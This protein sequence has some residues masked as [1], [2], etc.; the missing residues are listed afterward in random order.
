MTAF[1]LNLTPG[2]LA[3]NH[4]AKPYL[5]SP[6]ELSAL[7][8]R[9]AANADALIA[10]R[11]KPNKKPKARKGVAKDSR[12]GRPKKS[13]LNPFY[14]HIGATTDWGRYPA[15]AMDAVAGIARLDWYGERD[16]SAGKYMPLSQRDMMVVIE[17]LSLI[18]TDAVGEL[19][20]L[21]ER[22][23][24]RYVKAC[25][26]AI[27]YMMNERPARLIDQ[28]E[29]I[30]PVYQ[31]GNHQW[32]DIDY[33]PPPAAELAKLHHDLRDLGED[34]DLTTHVYNSNKQVLRTAGN[35]STWS[36]ASK[37]IHKHYSAMQMAA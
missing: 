20:C 32:E 21:G 18:T 30:E 26:M 11:V 2:T 4:D 25:E 10:A 17:S 23:S 37:K 6:A 28:M 9:I 16:A 31:F 24:Q 7:N 36:H 1:A 14:T 13:V 12:R 22:H 27:P 34:S 29:G 8:A 19:L 35:V 15:F 5:L 3:A 33:T